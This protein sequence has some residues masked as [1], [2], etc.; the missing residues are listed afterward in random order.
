MISLPAFR[1]YVLEEAL[2][3]LLQNSGYR[4]L[5]TAS[6]DPDALCAASSGLRVRGRGADHQVDVLG[7]LLVPTPFSLPMR[8]FAE[9]KCVSDPVGLAT[10]RNAHGVIHDVNEQF[11]T[12][13]VAA[14]A[15]PLR[16]HH[17]RYSLFSTS[18]FTAPAQSYAMAHQI[19]L[20]DLSGPAF[21]TLISTVF[22]T[23]ADIMNLI[24]GSGVQT[25]PTAEV[26]SLLRLALGTWTDVDTHSWLADLPKDNGELLEAVDA[27][28]PMSGL[29]PWEDLATL[30]LRLRKRLGQDLLFGFPQAPFSLV[31]RP[32]NLKDFL[33][34]I[35][36]RDEVPVNIRF[37]RRG[38]VS[39]DWVLVPSDGS[40][41]FVLRFGIP[42]VLETWL[43]SGGSGDTPASATRLARAA[44]SQLLGDIAVFH[45]QRV[46][47]LKYAP[48]EYERPLDEQ[49]TESQADD[50]QLRRA[51]RDEDLGLPLPDGRPT[52]KW[53]PDSIR[54]L[55]AR[56]RTQRAPQADVIQAAAR[57]GGALSRSQVLEICGPDMDQRSLTSFTKPVSRVTRLL[58][59]LGSVPSHVEPALT[60]RPGFTQKS[61][62]FE[63][64]P[65]FIHVL[66][67]G[68]DDEP[69]S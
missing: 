24:H 48:T 34:A 55:M 26:R 21:A 2:A 4:L 64:P 17:Y 51:L 12:S 65:E 45:H 54:E 47:H 14:R 59:A 20:V 67:L 62:A 52:A 10:I 11:A 41:S 63:V 50:S 18:G 35:G 32:D 37:A 22:R 1:G 46:V 58:I 31:L 16:R 61:A 9:A 36:R 60:P 7:E 3:Y 38:D 6:Q 68:H 8:M 29:L 49:P 66:G 28:T 69:T 39:G 33:R 5:V 43:L 53:S 44:K 56:L 15:V 13:N 19:T 23:A 42:A 25:F 27:T 40:A 57:A 30:A